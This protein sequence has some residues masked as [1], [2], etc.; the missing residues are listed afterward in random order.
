MILIQKK[1]F[2]YLCYNFFSSSVT[3][4][5]FILNIFI[6][7]FFK[8]ILIKYYRKMGF[9]RRINIFHRTGDDFADI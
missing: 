9:V 6:E 7:H 8:N 5:N 4:F 2:L 3:N 1:M